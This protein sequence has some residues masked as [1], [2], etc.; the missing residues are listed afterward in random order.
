MTEFHQGEESRGKHAP[1]IT[2]SF[3]RG[4]R[5]FKLIAQLHKIIPLT[6]FLRLRQF[7]VDVPVPGKRVK[8]I[9]T[10]YSQPVTRYRILN[11]GF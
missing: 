4:V 7:L 9:S 2:L 6:A 1:V 3:E 5:G 8:P 10:K 11:E